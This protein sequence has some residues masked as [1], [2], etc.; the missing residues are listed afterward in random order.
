VK[1]RVINSLL[2]QLAY[3]GYR[4]VKR[5]SKVLLSTSTKHVGHSFE[6]LNAQ[7]SRDKVKHALRDNRYDPALLA[8]LRRLETRNARST[9]QHQDD[10]PDAHYIAANARIL[11]VPLSGKESETRMKEL[12]I[13][14]VDSVGSQEDLIDGRNI[15]YENTPSIS[16]END[17]QG[18]K[19]QHN[20]VKHTHPK[21]KED[22]CAVATEG[23]T[24]SHH[25]IVPER[26]CSSLETVCQNAHPII[27]SP[28]LNR[29]MEIMQAIYALDV[30]SLNHLNC[31]LFLNH[32]FAMALNYM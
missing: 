26:I 2:D 7:E 22:K 23:G 5:S 17:I 1:A 20:T 16:N 19:E 27:P 24:F 11:N 21:Q 14:A 4:F 12:L 18:V 3:A 25:T 32:P 30:Q 10:I 28:I 6:T 13:E 31:H 8:S 15:L 9:C 29:D